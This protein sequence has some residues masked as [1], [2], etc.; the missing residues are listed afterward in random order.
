[1]RKATGWLCLAAMFLATA[2]VRAAAE[3]PNPGR[4]VIHS[5]APAPSWEHGMLV[6]NGRHGARVMGDPVRE[7][8][9]CNHEELFSRFWDRKIE[10]VADI[11][12]LLPEVRRLIDEDKE[13]E[14][15]TLSNHVAVRLLEEKGRIFRKAVIPHPAFDIYIEHETPGDPSDYRRQLDL[16]TGE[17]LTRWAVDGGGVEERVFS[18]R[19][20]NVNVIH[21]KGTGGRKLDVTLRL[22]EVPGRRSAKVK[23]KG[24][25]FGDCMKSSVEFSADWIIFDADYTLDPGGYQGVVRVIAK[26]GTKK[27]DDSGIRVSGAEEILLLVR[28]VAQ[29]DGSVSLVKQVKAEL[30]QMPADYDELFLPHAQQHGVMFLRS[31]LDLG[32]AAGWESTSTEQLI[33]NSVQDGVTPLFLEQV[34]AMGRYL[35]I[36]SCGKYPPPLQGIWGVSWNPPWQGGFVLDSNVNLAISSA[37]MSSLPECSQSYIN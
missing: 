35:T 22:A 32:A 7:R 24:T 1:M 3:S 34:Y 4:W 21:L 14:A 31:V 37:A 9:V 36:S 20:H 33:E 17:A 5:D 6:G 28:I 30:E 16:E 29:R 27:L 10:M 13:K 15:Y 8:I 11:A 12:E 26:G 19:P 23:L 25:S 2:G 18:S